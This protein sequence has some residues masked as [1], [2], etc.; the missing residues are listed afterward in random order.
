MPRTT[1]AGQ[2]QQQLSQKP[3]IDQTLLGTHAQREAEKE[4]TRSTR[5]DETAESRIRDQ[6]KGNTGKGD[7]QQA[8]GQASEGETTEGREVPAPHPYKGRHF[9][10][11]F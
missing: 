2:Q 7:G 9:D 11:T 6:N 1:D 8:D 5:L 3:V 10:I 4:R